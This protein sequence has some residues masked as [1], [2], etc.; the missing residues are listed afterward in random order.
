MK[1]ESFRKIE[2]ARHLRG[3]GDSG[4]DFL[5][6]SCFLFALVVCYSLW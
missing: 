3:E 4:K 6:L 1:G 5:P 2:L